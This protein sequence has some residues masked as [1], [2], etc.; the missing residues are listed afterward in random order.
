MESLAQI[1]ERNSIAQERFEASKIGKLRYM[2]EKSREQFKIDADRF[3]MHG[4]SHEAATHMVQWITEV[5]N[6]TK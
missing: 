2:L 4:K 6:E 5:L 1:V 3:E